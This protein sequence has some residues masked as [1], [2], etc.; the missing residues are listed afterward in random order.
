M[1][2]IEVVPN[3]VRWNTHPK[4]PNGFPIGNTV[5]VSWAAANNTSPGNARR[6]SQISTRPHMR[7]IAARGGKVRVP[8]IRKLSQH[9]RRVTA[10][11]VGIVRRVPGMLKADSE[12]EAYVAFKDS[13]DLIHGT[14]D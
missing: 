8:V 7:D 3:F 4:S 1:A 14:E 6:A 9:R 10:R 5:R 11:V 13:L 12:R 2:G